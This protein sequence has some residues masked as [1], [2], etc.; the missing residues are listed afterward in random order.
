MKQLITKDE[1]FNQLQAHCA[2]VEESGEVLFESDTIRGHFIARL[3]HVELICCTV[4]F[5][6]TCKTFDNN[7]DLFDLAGSVKAMTELKVLWE[8]SFT[9]FVRERIN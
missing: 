9:P 1:L 8:K 4:N 5:E 7:V 3:A 2:T 6:I